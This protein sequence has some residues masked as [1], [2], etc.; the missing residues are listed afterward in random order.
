V[1][2]HLGS[3]N[4]SSSRTHVRFQ[5]TT[6]AG[7]GAA[8]APS[9]AFENADLRIYKAT[10]GAAFSATQ[11]SSTAGI[12]MTSPFDGLTGLHDVDIDL[13]D[14]TDAGFY[15]AG[16]YSVVLSPDTET[17]DS[18]AVIRVLAYFDIG[19]QPANVTQWLGTAASTPTVAGV[20]NVNAKTWND[21][22]TVALPLIPTTAGRTLD[23][24]ATGEA[25]LDFD[26]IKHATGSHTLTNV[27]VPVVTTV[28]TLTTYTGNTPQTGDVYPKVDTEI[29]T[30]LTAA[31]AIQAKTDNLPS[32]PADA[33]DVAAALASLASTL[34][35][36][37]SYIDTEVAS[38]KAKTDSLTFTAAGAVD[39]NVKRLNDVVLTGDG[40]ATPFGV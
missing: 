14:N 22:A 12:T 19:P 9:S 15:G 18:V 1:A 2:D 32:D 29:A 25:G 34:A 4:T 8:V 28:G 7:S 6:H 26:N 33:S 35:T 40:S 24:A 13:T 27:T 21:L 31:A 11:L 23:V 3:Y 39:A 37:A 16:F 38:I 10:D 30:L 36:I 5:F 17:V 20:P